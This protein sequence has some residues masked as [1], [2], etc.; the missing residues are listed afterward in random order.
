MIRY[1][2]GRLMQAVILVLMIAAFVFTYNQVLA[3]VNLNNGGKSLT[4]EMRLKFSDKHSSE[5][6]PFKVSIINL[7][8]S[9]GI[10]GKAYLCEAGVPTQGIGMAKVSDQ[11]ISWDEI[12]SGFKKVYIRAFKS[13]FRYK[14]LSKQQRYALTGF[15]FNVTPKGDLK[16]ELLKKNPDP[17]RI[18]NLMVK[19]NKVKNPNWKKNN[20]QREYIISNGLR[21]RR[22]RDS[23]IFLA[24]PEVLD[25]LYRT[26]EAK[27]LLMLDNL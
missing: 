26:L 11:E 12:Q 10:E 20:D 16:R 14:Y 1:F 6:L 24:S 5:S 18:V 27:V 8:Y 17:D 7:I 23:L 21:K 3:I 4:E 19:Y 25:S 9:E 22:S 13:T 2:F 15:V